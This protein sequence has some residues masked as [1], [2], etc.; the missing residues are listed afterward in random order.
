MCRSQAASIFISSSPLPVGQ[1]GPPKQTDNYKLLPTIHF[2]GDKDHRRPLGARCM[3]ESVQVGP[4]PTLPSWPGSQEVDPEA[5]TEAHLIIPLRV[6][7][8]KRQSAGVWGG[9]SG[10]AADKSASWTNDAPS[11]WG[12]WESEPHP[13]GWEPCPPAPSLST[14][15]LRATP[16]MHQHSALHPCL[17]HLH[18][19]RVQVIE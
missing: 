7:C 13:R 3:P 9:E 5:K 2:N 10:R 6:E 8:R 14:P 16:R 11:P 17:W 15:W 4:I 18:R 12:L 19:W 1:T